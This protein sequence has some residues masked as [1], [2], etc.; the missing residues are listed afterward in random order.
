MNTNLKESL[1][2]DSEE[3]NVSKQ[4]KVLYDKTPS[5]DEAKLH[6]SRSDVC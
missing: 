6:F 5:K 2:E 4:V 1:E 3:K